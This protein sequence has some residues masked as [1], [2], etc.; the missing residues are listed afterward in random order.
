MLHEKVS[1]KQT[2]SVLLNLRGLSSIVRGYD[3][4]KVC[5]QFTIASGRTLGAA[6]LSQTDLRTPSA[7]SDARCAGISAADGP[8]IEL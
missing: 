3:R 1:K 8:Q 6:T 4:L 5:V 2:P 7:L